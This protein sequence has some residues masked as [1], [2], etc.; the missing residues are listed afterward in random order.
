MK[1][2]TVTASILLAALLQPMEEFSVHL[3]EKRREYTRTRMVRIAPYL[4]ADSVASYCTDSIDEE[5]VPALFD[6]AELDE[7][8]EV[9]D[10][11][12]A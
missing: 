8:L 2:L 11:A 7:G 10:H 9:L 12:L 5:N 1:A 6:A 4:V 3:Y